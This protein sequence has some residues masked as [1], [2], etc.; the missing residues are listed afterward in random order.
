MVAGSYG[1]T[2]LDAQISS[3]TG[4]SQ[5]C[6]DG[7]PGERNDNGEVVGQLVGGRSERDVHGHGQRRHVRARAPPTGTV[8]FLD[9]GS[10]LATATSYPTG[11]KQCH[12]LH[13]S[14]TDN[15]NGLWSYG[16]T[17]TFGSTFT[18]DTNHFNYRGL[19]EWCPSIS[20]DAHACASERDR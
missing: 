20:S 13:F 15:P 12:R 9:N 7:Q 16:W 1:N 19:D 3:L 18:L 11:R 14:P 4:G 2:P 17:Q 5:R 10:T 8:T 6:P